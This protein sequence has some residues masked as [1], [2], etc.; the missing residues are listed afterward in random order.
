MSRAGIFR[1]TNHEGI[2]SDH[3][4]ADA[5]V[6]PEGLSRLFAGSAD[7]SQRALPGGLTVF[8]LDTLVSSAHLAEDVIR[9]LTLWGDPERIS[10]GSVRRRESLSDLAGDLLEGCCAVLRGGAAWSAEVKSEAV[11]SVDKPAVEK[12]VK[13][14]KDSFVEVLRTNVGLVR[15]R[16]R[17][18][19]LKL[20][21]RVV[22]RTGRICVALC[23]LEGKAD[24]TLLEEVRRRLDALEPEALLGAG[25]L[26]RALSDRPGSPFPQLLHTERPDKFAAELSDGRVGLLADGLPLGFVLPA[27]LGSFFRVAEDAAQHPAIGALL[28]ALRRCAAF[29]SAFFPALLAAVCMYHPEMIPT[30]LLLSMIEAKQQVPFSVAFEML[31]M[32][33][34]FELLMEAGLR[35]PDP[36]GDTVSIIGALIIGQSAVEARIVSPFSVIVVATAAI[37]GFTQ[38]SRD[39]G[40]AL[41]LCR[42]ALLALA[43]ALGLYGVML[44]AAALGWYLCT[45]ESCGRPYV[46]GSQEL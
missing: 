2:P 36:V 43:I 17:T 13:G 6:S 5:R 10:A 31:T 30:R 11:R 7:F 4:A 37:C 41:R 26:E 8:W 27:P 20:E 33:A 9:P 25:R 45:L 22:G 14:S 28:R 15:R 40:A 39:L 29:V 24:G 18:P 16:L 38:P 1:Q 12:S 34:A 35:L 23:W 3:P 44:G 32:L 19:A 42:F 21:E 46:G